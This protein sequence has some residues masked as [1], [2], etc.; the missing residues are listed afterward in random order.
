M[1]GGTIKGGTYAQ[2]IEMKAGT[3]YTDEKLAVV[4]GSH[5][6]TYML[7]GAVYLRQVLDDTVWPTQKTAPKRQMPIL[8]AGITQTAH[9][10]LS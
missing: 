7:D 2:P 3:V 1:S 5:L 10:W 8:K 6:L 4:D 9:A